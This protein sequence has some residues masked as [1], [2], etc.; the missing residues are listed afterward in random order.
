MM[1]KSFHS[2]LPIFYVQEWSDKET[3]VCCL[4]NKK[5]ILI[6]SKENPACAS[7]ERKWSD[8]LIAGISSQL[9]SELYF[10]ELVKHVLQPVTLSPDTLTKSPKPERLSRQRRAYRWEGG[11]CLQRCHFKRREC[12]I[13]PLLCTAEENLHEHQGYYQHMWRVERSADQSQSKKRKKKK[14]RKCK[15]KK[16]KRK[17]HAGLQRR[18]DAGGYSRKWPLWLYG[19]SDVQWRCKGRQFLSYFFSSR[20]HCRGQRET[21]GL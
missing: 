14:W 15:K 21:P 16:K 4:W 3:Q 17:S 1:S 7:L 10:E 6:E 5:E 19:I 9:Q 8:D 12:I 11:Q 18:E 20:D 2:Y 13:Q